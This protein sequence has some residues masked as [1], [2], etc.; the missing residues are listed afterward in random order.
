MGNVVLTKHETV[1]PRTYVDEMG[2]DFEDRE[3]G[4]GM[5]TYVWLSRQ[6]YDDMGQPAEIT[7]TVVPG[8]Q[9]NGEDS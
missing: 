5:S 6:N 2:A 7:V 1:L 4:V 9:L 3:E 8:D